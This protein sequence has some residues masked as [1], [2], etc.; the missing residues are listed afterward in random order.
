MAVG[1]SMNN[2]R[3]TKNIAAPDIGNKKL[4]TFVNFHLH[5]H[6]DLVTGLIQVLWGLRNLYILGAILKKNNRKNIFY[7]LYMP[8]EHISRVPPRILEGVPINKGA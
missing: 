3:F 5:V 2:V 4:D 8:S 1:T 6:T 7:K